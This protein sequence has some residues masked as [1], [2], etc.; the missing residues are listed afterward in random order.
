VRSEV[1]E[2]NKC[3]THVENC[4][5]GSVPATSAA[6]TSRESPTH[7]GITWTPHVSPRS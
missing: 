7:G 6:T 2:R 5:F 3:V 1:L 4:G